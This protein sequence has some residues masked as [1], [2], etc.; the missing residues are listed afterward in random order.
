MLAGAMQRAGAIVAGLI[1]LAALPAAAQ[2]ADPFLEDGP[3]IAPRTGPDPFRMAPEQQA[4]TPPSAPRPRPA[5]EP[6][7][8]PEPVA[9]VPPPPPR[10]SYDGDYR[11]AQ[12]PMDNRSSCRCR[13]MGTVE[14]ALSIA[15]GHFSWAY[16][17][18]S[19]GDI[20]RGNVNDAGEVSGFAT[21]SDGGLRIIGNIR[22]N[23]FTGQVYSTCC[24]YKI[25]M[26]KGQ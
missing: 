22:G 16:P 3:S 14:R 24:S 7:S 26:S 4:V 6:Q 10:P 21:R 18:P 17:G 1:L 13:S 5:P 12:I 19:S 23:E 20:I 2:E 11:G 25:Q 8:Q 15:G 9:I